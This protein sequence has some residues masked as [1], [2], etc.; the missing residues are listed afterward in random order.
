MTDRTVRTM[1][2]MMIFLS[3][4]WCASSF[5]RLITDD[6]PGMKELHQ[7]TLEVG[8]V[9]LLFAVLGRILIWTKR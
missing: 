2:V 5:V 4:G 1:N 3:L 9:I 7:Y 6:R 8:L